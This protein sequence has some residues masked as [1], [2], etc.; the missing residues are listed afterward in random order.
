MPNHLSFISLIRQID[1][2]LTKKYTEAEVI[3]AVISA[4]S[5]SSHLRSY[6]ES[7]KDF[8]LPKLRKINRSFYNEKSPTEIYNQLT[9]LAKSPNE[10]A[11]D[12][13]FRALMI[14]QKVLFTSLEADT[15][16][17]YN[18]SLTQGL[19]LHAIET[20]LNDDN[21]RT[22]I[23]PLLQQP[24]VTDEELIEQVNKIMAAET[25][26]NRKFGLG[27]RSRAEGK[28]GKINLASADIN[29]GLGTTMEI[30]G[31]DGSLDNSGKN[32]RK[33]QNKGNL[34]LHLKQ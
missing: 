24:G 25:E 6:L 9:S 31:R 1:T 22:R 27:A 18:P 19:F 8:T 3:E 33:T 26:R 17:S 34:Q 12:F 7:K 21:I 28:Q 4:I 30:K 15:Y 32:L 2:A 16:I 10:T 23:R 11:Q 13:L 5:P 29:V 14:R 20:G